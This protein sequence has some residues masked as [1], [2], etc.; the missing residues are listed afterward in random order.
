MARDFPPRLKI[1]QQG[2]GP[3]YRVTLGDFDLSNLLMGVEVVFHQGQFPAAK[4]IIDPSHVELDSAVLA[5]LEAH[6][7]EQAS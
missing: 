3:Q 4:L 1:E 5:R 6:V 2:D 7:R